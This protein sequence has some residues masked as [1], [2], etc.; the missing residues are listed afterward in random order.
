MNPDIDYQ[1]F[2]DDRDGQTYKFVKIGDHWWMAENL[3]FEVDSSFCYKDSAG[4][5]EKYGRLYKWEVA[6]H[7]C[8][9]GWLLPGNGDFETFTSMLAAHTSLLIPLCNGCNK[10]VIP[11]L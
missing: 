11:F 6:D 5:C 7:V 10:N 3:N 4:Y 2:V 9:S 8:Q 1:E